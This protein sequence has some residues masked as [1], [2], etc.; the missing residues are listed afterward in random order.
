MGYAPRK[1]TPAGR[2]RSL[3]LWKVLFE[4]VDPTLF[5]E[6]GVL[7]MARE[8]DPLT[9]STLATLER[10]GVPHERLSRVQLESR[11]PQVEFRPGPLSVRRR[12]DVAIHEPGSGVLMARRASRRSSRE[13]ERQGVRYVAAAVKS[14]QSPPPAGGS[15]QSPRDRVRG[16]GGALFIFAC[17]PWL[18]KLFP[19]L[20]GDR[21]FATRQEVLY[22]GPPAGDSRFAAPACRRGSISARRCTASP[23]SR[24][25]LQDLAGPSRRALRP[26]TDERV[27]GQTLPAV[28]DYMARRFPALR[29]APLAGAEVC[30]YENT[31][32]GDFS[33]DRHPELENVWLVGGGSGHGFKHGPVVRRVRR[34]TCS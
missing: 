14:V 8:H 20:L 5:R 11:W 16:I 12:G 33:D 27:A 22:F 15:K 24:R 21:I 32:N 9:T 1:S 2:S 19:D 4:R 25:G 29:N 31:C 34:A 13:A 18:P 17:G 30:Q 10:V 28:R 7:W 6:T 3:E 26:D 23:T